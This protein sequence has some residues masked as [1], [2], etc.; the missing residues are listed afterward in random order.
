MGVA[1]PPGWPTNNLWVGYVYDAPIGASAPV[2]NDD[3]PTP[4][5][6]TADGCLIYGRLSRLTIASGVPPANRC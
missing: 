6:P 5:G 3:C 1:I 2:W 4:P